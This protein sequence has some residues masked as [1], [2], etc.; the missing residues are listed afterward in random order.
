MREGRTLKAS[1][2]RRRASRRSRPPILCGSANSASSSRAVS[3]KPC[4]RPRHGIGTDGAPTSAVLTRPICRIA[5]PIISFERRRCAA[6]VTLWRVVAFVAAA[7]AILFAVCAA[8]GDTTSDLQARYRQGASVRR[9]HGP[10]T[11]AEAAS[12]GRQ[13]ERGGRASRSTVPAAR[14]K[15]PRRSMRKSAASRRRSRSSRSSAAWRRRAPISP[16]W[17]PT[18]FSRAAIRSSGRSACSCN[19]PMFPGFWTSSGSNT[20]RS[21]RRR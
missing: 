7:I 20:R 16:R 15:G 5:P 12:R 11:H 2:S 1:A 6:R 3:R 9:H 10:G 18:A 8:R 13:F 21:S 19:F 14:P 17:A 4:K